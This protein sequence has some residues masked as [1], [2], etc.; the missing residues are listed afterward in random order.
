MNHLLNHRDFS[1][2]IF[3]EPIQSSIEIVSLS[4]DNDIKSKEVFDIYV[5]NMSAG[6]L[7]FVSRVEFTVNFLSIYKITLKL[8]DRE[9][10]LFGKVIRKR[11]L[12]DHF[13][14][15]GVVFDFNYYQKM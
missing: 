9:L 1:R 13:F 5:L 3:N 6:G 11:R 15:Y 4:Y 12:S 8:K 2:V 7:R 14:D 10:V